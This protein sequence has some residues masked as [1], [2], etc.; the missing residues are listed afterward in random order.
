MRLA[1]CRAALVATMVCFQ[2]FGTSQARACPPK[3]S[4]EYYFPAKTW[5]PTQSENDKFIG[6][7]YSSMLRAMK[8]PSIS[9]GRVGTAYRFLWLRTFH[10]PVAVR[11]ADI[12]NQLS[13]IAVEL[14][15]EGGYT[16]GK[17]L[18]RENKRLT[19]VE[20]QPLI[21]TLSRAEFWKMPINNDPLD[22]GL[23]G[24]EWVLE[25]G[26]RDQ[27][28]VVARWTPQSGVVRDL[29]LEFLKLAGWKFE[30]REMY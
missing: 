25:V 16:P 20:M 11:I 6:G 28:H 21:D 10:H 15:G 23:D 29:G 2:F 13:I 12:Q 14:D 7:W 9:C 19:Y 3:S 26:S 18:R 4:S 22:I 1:T 30:G 8:E 27:Y 24:S 17:V 5:N